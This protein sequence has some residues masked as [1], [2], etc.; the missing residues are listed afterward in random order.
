MAACAGLLL[1]RGDVCCC[2][3]RR[4]RA[5]LAVA[6]QSEPSLSLGWRYL[7][8]C[9]EGRPL[10]YTA[11]VAGSNPPVSLG[12]WDRASLYGCC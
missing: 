4:S 8:G 5:H 1:E 10:E 11:M 2:C 6:A 9:C 3:D 12:P 7:R